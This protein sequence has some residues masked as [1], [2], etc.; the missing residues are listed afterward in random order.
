M[1]RRPLDMSYLNVAPGRWNW[2][3]WG[4]MVMAA[5]AYFLVAGLAIWISL[6]R[7]GGIG[8]V[9]AIMGSFVIGGAV[10]RAGMAARRKSR[11]T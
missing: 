6:K 11:S 4:F 9:L 8:A 2:L 1:P 7:F 10:F 5:I 3:A